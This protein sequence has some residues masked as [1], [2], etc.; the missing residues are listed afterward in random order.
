MMP[1][2][3]I[4]AGGR[5]TR[6]RSIT[7]DSPK[8]L[9]QVAGRPFLEHVL[10]GLSRHGFGRV[11]LAVGYGREQ[12]RAHFNDRYAGIDL[13]Y[14]EENEPLGTGGAVRQALEFSATDHVF[15]LNGD[16][17][18]SVDYSAMFYAHLA[19]GA[20]LSIAVA[21][22]LELGR[23]GAVDITDGRVS[24]FREKGTS[25]PGYINAGIYLT[26]RALFSSLNVPKSFSFE[27]DVLEAHLLSLRPLAFKTDGEFIDI[28]VPADY[29]RA[30][31][32]FGA[33]TA[34]HGTQS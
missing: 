32:Q 18:V 8:V 29:A 3:I 27:R 19:Q 11:V 17:W 4:L 9:A 12:I 16:T 24:S 7:G 1:E 31:A 13:V 21:S 34:V 20:Q 23:F 10:D 5:G 15:V 25:G 26:R 6:L 30:N 28:G 22:V 14:S 33:L 2:A